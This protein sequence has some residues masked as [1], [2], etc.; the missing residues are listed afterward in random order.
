MSEGTQEKKPALSPPPRITAPRSADP[1]AGRDGN[2]NP[3][4]TRRLLHMAVLAALVLGLI[5]V[6]ILLPRWQDRRQDDVVTTG[7]VREIETPTPQPR[8]PAAPTEDAALMTPSPTPIPTRVPTTVPTRPGNTNP[9]QPSAEERQYVEAMSEG[10]A[11]LNDRRWQDALEAFERAARFRP[12][13]PE[14]TDGRARARAGQRQETIAD[15][16][17][18]ARELEQTEA[19]REAERA[20]S[21]VLALDPESA[22]ALEGQGATETRADLD[23]RIEFHLANPARLSSSEVFAD[24][25]AALAEALETVPSGTRLESQ[26]ARL[27]HLL[28]LVSTPVTVILESD[29]Q[30]EVVVYRVGRL[31][32]FTRRELH[33]MPGAYTVVGSRDGYRDVRLQLVVTPGSPPDPLMVR[34]TEGL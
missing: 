4:T 28:E 6:F 30:T 24:A 13:A 22:D 27:E 29:H 16:L 34:C 3:R 20:Y 14:V 32:T 23:E 25:A 10:L 33:L 12:D 11:A 26:I 9:P 21:A 15:G 18:R 8:G 7:T 19:W 17:R 2:H 1:G 31:G 5:G